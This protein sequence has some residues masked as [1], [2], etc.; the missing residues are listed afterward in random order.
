MVVEC[1]AFFSMKREFKYHP[2]GTIGNKQG[3]VLVT[4]DATLQNM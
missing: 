4:R 1:D 3:E 2:A